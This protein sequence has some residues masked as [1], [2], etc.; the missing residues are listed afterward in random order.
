MGMTSLQKKPRRA[1]SAH[2]EHKLSN[3]WMDTRRYAFQT[4]GVGKETSSNP[5]G[6]DRLGFSDQ[7]LRMIAPKK[8][9]IAATRPLTPAQ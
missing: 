7:A 4:D 2:S 3:Y 6:L 9:R 5:P 1:H 8:Q